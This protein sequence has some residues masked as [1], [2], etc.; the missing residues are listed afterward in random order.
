MQWT[1]EKTALAGVFVVTP[2]VFGDERGF[3]KETYSA[4]VFRDNGIAIDFV[5]DNHSL[6]RQAGTLRGI[7]FQTGAQAQAKLVRCVAG[8]ILDIAVDLG[9]SSPTF[10]RWIAT[11]LSPDN[12]RQLFVPAGFGHAFLTL[13]DDS[14]VQYSVSRPYSKAHDAAVRWDDPDI[15]IDWPVARAD[16]ILSQK[17]AAAPLLRDAPVLF[18]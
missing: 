15:A 6:S 12:H 17:D 18:D 13:E 2:P 11:E 3:F 16:V 5:Q 1:F 9:R 4:R 14:E 8:R 7:H 10:A